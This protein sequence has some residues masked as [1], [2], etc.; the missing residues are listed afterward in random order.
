MPPKCE[1]SHL[2]VYAGTFCFMLNIH[3]L[4]VVFAFGLSSRS[5]HSLD[6]TEQ[7]S[8]S[9]SDVSYFWRWSSVVVDTIRY[10]TAHGTSLIRRQSDHQAS[11]S[12]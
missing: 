11:A 6:S 12:Y 1:A 4:T 9:I 10:D 5:S 3:T 7:H 2:D 8:L